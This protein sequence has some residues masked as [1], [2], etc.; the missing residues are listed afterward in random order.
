[1]LF[2]LT[3][4]IVQQEDVVTVTAEQA[5]IF[6]TLSSGKP[7]ASSTDSHHSSIHPSNLINLIHPLY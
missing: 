7:Q 6:Q 4:E 3:N 1:M 2:N 5:W